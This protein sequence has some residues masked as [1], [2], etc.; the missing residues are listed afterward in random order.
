MEI[1]LKQLTELINGELYGD[2]NATV[3]NISTVENAK[4][5]DITFIANKKYQKYIYSTK[6]TAVIIS[7]HVKDSNVNQIVVDNPYLAY[8]KILTFYTSRAVSYKG[9]S[10]QAFISPEVFFKNKSKV[11]IYPFVFI[12][13]NS[14]IGNNVVIYPNVTIGKNVKIG[15][16]VKIYSNVS[17]YDNS[18]IGNYVTVHSGTVIGSD[19]YGYA[20]EGDIHFKIP[21]IGNVIIEDY[22]EI[23]AN[24]TIDR[25]AI[26]ST[27]I[28]KGTKIDNLVHIAHNV[29]IGENT[30]VVAQ[31]GISGSSKVGKNVILAGQVGVAG[32]LKI[33]DNVMVGAQSGIG[34]DLP[35]NSVVSGSPAV[36]HSKWLRWAVSYFKLPDLM[37]RVNKLEKALERI[38]D[39]NTRNL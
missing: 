33:G 30:L 39:S 8:A 19:G 16:N 35:D 25:G 31:V 14:E 6:A 28:K 1:S 23:G 9:I 17:I 34:K 22:V 11:T 29:E 32:H 20:K 36:E 2:P 7:K 15:D 27:I 5:G 24:C 12:G 18:L 13:E 38:N 4:E 37:K 21:Q 10:D 26:N 3:N